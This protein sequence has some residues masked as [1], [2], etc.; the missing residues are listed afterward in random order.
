MDKK[1]RLPSQGGMLFVV[2][3]LLLLLLA[4][5]RVLPISYRFSEIA[6]YLL[7]IILVLHSVEAVVAFMIAR[8]KRANPVKWAILTLVFGIFALIPLRNQ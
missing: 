7:A 2:A 6:G 5:L 3:G 1:E 4:W 8:K